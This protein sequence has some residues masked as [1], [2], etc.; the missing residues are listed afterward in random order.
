MLNIYSNKFINAI[1]D[2]DMIFHKD[3]FMFKGETVG[4]AEGNRSRQQVVATVKTDQV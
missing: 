2:Y 4:V 1:L 3:Y